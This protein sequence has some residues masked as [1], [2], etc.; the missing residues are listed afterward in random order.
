MHGPALGKTTDVFVELVQFLFSTLF[1]P[2]SCWDLLQ[3]SLFDLLGFY[4]ASISDWF[5]SVFF[6]LFVKFLF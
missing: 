3:S 2:S 5:S 4:I 1:D 6:N